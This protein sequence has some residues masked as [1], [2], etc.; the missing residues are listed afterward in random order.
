MNCT[1]L[2]FFK[3]ITIKKLKEG[4]ELKLQAILLFFM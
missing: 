3:D 2:I 1:S 4:R